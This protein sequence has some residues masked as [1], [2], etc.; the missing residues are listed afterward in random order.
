M[1]ANTLFLPDRYRDQWKLMEDLGGDP[2]PIYWVEATRDQ[3]V[4]VIV[5]GVPNRFSHWT[6]G[7]Q[8]LRMLQS[9]GRIYEFVIWGPTMEAYID[10]T[11]SPG[12]AHL[13]AGHV[14][15]HADFMRHNF[16]FNAQ[17]LL[18][19]EDWAHHA[20]WIETHERK[21]NAALMEY[22]QRYTHRKSIDKE[23]DG[24]WNV[25]QVFPY[26]EE[27][28]EYTA[29]DL[30]VSIAEHTML[31]WERERPIGIPR[32]QKQAVRVPT[33]EPERKVDPAL[34]S[35][36]RT[37]WSQVD[38]LDILKTFA[39]PEGIAQLAAIFQEESDYFHVL[40]ATKLMNEGWATYW[41]HK[42]SLLGA[43]EYDVWEQAHLRS[44]VEHPHAVNPYWL[45]GTLFD[46]LEQDGED[47]RELMQH[48]DDVSFL[49]HALTPRRLQQLELVPMVV[50]AG[51]D[52]AGNPVWNFYHEDGDPEV[53][54]DRF[55]Q[56]WQVM[57]RGLG[58]PSLRWISP[59]E[60]Q[61]EEL[62]GMNQWFPDAPQSV[63][64]AWFIS[65]ATLLGRT[66]TVRVPR[67]IDFVHTED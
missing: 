28:E 19:A 20:Q 34:A 5:H 6:F 22:A 42:L 21:M 53:I 4:R 14:M 25:Y 3:M 44:A 10:N 45:G 12:E 26:A 65:L 66:L 56:Y 7:E 55:I 11:L 15:G 18:A 13:I 52:D 57:K 29:L 30:M 40:K 63:D 39:R 8:Y 37:T 9:P 46:L 61:V 54:I 33:T 35:M 27:L 16:R 49:Y 24:I 17:Y 60:V 32:W 31:P 36:G 38:T 67:T 1:S 51:I 64:P 62:W 2:G 58:T 47:P 41:H 50:R 43:T 59:K 48:Y 23:I